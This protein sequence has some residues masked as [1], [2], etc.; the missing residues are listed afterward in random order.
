M[1]NESLAWVV[2]RLTREAE[3]AKAERERL[4]A[5]AGARA[6]SADRLKRYLLGWLQS[7]ELQR[8]ET[9]RFVVRI[10]KNGRPSFVVAPD[11]ELPV[12]FRRVRIEKDLTALYEAWK[13]DP[14][15]LPDGVTAETGWHVRIQ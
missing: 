12:E 8:V 6:N 4:D 5:L 14:E 9:P 1:K 3:A 11:T 10:Q 2:Q 13:R 7:M 15:G